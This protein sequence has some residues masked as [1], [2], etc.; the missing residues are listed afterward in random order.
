V[1]CNRTGEVVLMNIEKTL[2][3]IGC[4]LGAFYLLKTA[5]ENQFKDSEWNWE[6]D[7]NFLGDLTSL[8]EE[9]K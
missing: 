7:E 5:Y 9:Q 3:I 8:K 4:S 6:Y 2:I 1:G